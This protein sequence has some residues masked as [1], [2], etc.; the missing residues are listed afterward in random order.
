[1]VKR[2]FVFLLL[3]GILSTTVHAGATIV[4]AA[5]QIDARSYVVMD[6]NS[7]QILA[8]KNPDKREEPAS[9]TKMMTVYIVSDEIAAGRV[10]LNDE[11]TVSK[12]AWQMSGSRM[13]IEVGKKVS[14][15][16]LLKGVLVDS[17]NDASVALAEHVAGSED[18]FAAMMN[19][20]AKKLGMKGTHFANATGLPEPNHYS[21]ARDLAILAASLIRHFPQTYA[22][23]SLKQFTFDGITQHNRN[24]LLWQDPT[25]D[26]VKTGHT[27][28]AGY[29]LV[30]S[31][32]R[33]GMR[34]VSV[35]M[36]TD[37][38]H[39][40]VSDSQT[41][42][43]YA[44]RFYETHKLYSANE[45]VTSSRV[46]KGGRDSVDLGIS[47]DLYITIPRGSYKKLDAKSEIDRTLIAPIH[48][49]AIEGSLKVSLNGKELADRKLIALESIGEGS[50]YDR[51][52]D[53]VQLF[54]R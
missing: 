44:F 41:L 24:G 33:D 11:V 6:F 22:L 36:G 8:A 39:A 32:K 18:V 53:E 47:S 23:N 9:L 30:A 50:L 42:L 38:A 3:S 2:L 7:G 15:E 37:S 20:Y 10:K 4:P 29:C 40:R 1:M 46:W 17:G 13:F 43:N 48:K 21:T 25:V 16:D 31:A 19:Q 35:V 27:E 28:D 12:K 49:G 54:F 45:V 26:G 52:K 5:P 34:L 14:V 51:L